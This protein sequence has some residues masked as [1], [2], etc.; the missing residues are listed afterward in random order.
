[1]P[2]CHVTEKRK[3]FLEQLKKD[4]DFRH[5]SF[6]RITNKFCAHEALILK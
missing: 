1:M 4:P 6:E 2:I 5:R 3:L